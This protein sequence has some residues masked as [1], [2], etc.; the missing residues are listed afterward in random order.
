MDQHSIRKYIFI[1]RL[2]VVFDRVPRDTLMGAG[3]IMKR[4]RVLSTPEHRLDRDIG[5]AH[6]VL[7]QSSEAM[8]YPMRCKLI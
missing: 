7:F 4:Q 8:F 2:C 5:L 1:V 3:N 6:H